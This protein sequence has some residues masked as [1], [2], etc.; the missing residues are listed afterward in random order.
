MLLSILLVLHFS[1]ACGGLEMQRSIK[2]KFKLEYSFF[3]VQDVFY[4][5]LFIM[6]CFFSISG[7]EECNI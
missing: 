2:D 3:V 5:L 1:Q 7:S 4:T 6:Y